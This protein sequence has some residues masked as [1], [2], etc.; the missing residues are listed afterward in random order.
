MSSIQS[1]TRIETEGFTKLWLP[2]PAK[3]KAENG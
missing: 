2:N 1:I 3:I